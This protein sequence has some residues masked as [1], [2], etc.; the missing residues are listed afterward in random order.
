[1]FAIQTRSPLI[2]RDLGLL[3]SLRTRTRLRVGFS[4][5]TDRDDVRRVFEP[6]CASVE[7]RWNAIES[8]CAA[9]IDTSVTLAPIL[10]CNPEALIDKAVACSIGPLIADPLHVR[11]AKRFGATTRAAAEAICERHGWN[12]W[13]EPVF[14]QAILV[15]MKRR[16]SAAGREIGCGPA[17]FG[18]LARTPSF[19]TKLEA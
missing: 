10:P 5:T 1:V 2:L 16:A 17:G 11:A 14:Q 15:R 19:Y 8:L 3:L 13:L 6:H 9:G 18:M 7:E 4:I 12:D